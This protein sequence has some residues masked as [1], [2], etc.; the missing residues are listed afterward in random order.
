[1]YGNLS[2]IYGEKENFQKE[3]ATVREDTLPGSAFVSDL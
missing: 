1:M 3:N 2:E